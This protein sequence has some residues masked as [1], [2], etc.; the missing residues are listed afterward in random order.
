[1]TELI[2]PM[3]SLVVLTTLVALATAYIR[4]KSAYSGVVH[5]KY[6]KQFSTEYDVP[7]SMVQLGRNLNNLF[8]VPVLFYVVCLLTIVLNIAAPL[9]LT[10]AWLF[11]V[12]RVVHTAI[13]ITYNHPLHRFI[14]FALS[15]VCVVSMWGV[16]VIHVASS[17]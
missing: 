5:P 15:L 8:E 16:V 10:L 12:F 13:H 9:L 3:F 14:P 17:M 6:F 7:N 11:V 1:M 2:Y 4:I